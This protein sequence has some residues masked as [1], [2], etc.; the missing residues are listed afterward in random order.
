MTRRRCVPTLRGWSRFGE[1]GGAAHFDSVAAPDHLECCAEVVTRAS[2][3]KRSRHQRAEMGCAMR[4]A[5]P[6][7]EVDASPSAIFDENGN[8]RGPI[9]KFNVPVAAGLCGRQ[10]MLPVDG[11]GGAKGAPYA[12]C[13]EL[14]AA[15]RFIAAILKVPEPPLPT[16]ETTR[17]TLSALRLSSIPLLVSGSSEADLRRRQSDA[18]RRSCWQRCRES[19]CR[20]LR[21]FTRAR[22]WDRTDVCDGLFPRSS[23]I[24]QCRCAKK[25]GFGPARR[26]WLMET[27]A[28][29][30]QACGDAG[31]G[32]RGSG[33]CWCGWGS[34]PV[35]ST[36]GAAGEITSHRWL[37]KFP[38][39]AP[40][41][42]VCSHAQNR[43][44]STAIG[45]SD[46][47]ERSGDVCVL[48]WGCGRRSAT[49]QPRA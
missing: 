45:T 49:G 10:P 24:S 4:P 29:S 26:G 7:R 32:R 39:I 16:C 37:G 13:A 19:R 18:Q 46:A 20:D 27:L 30:A 48:R 23:G 8:A 21:I 1:L 3:E 36:S 11:I 6:Q 38:T 35:C 31:A 47:G 41:L 14:G 40:E 9:E 28:G 44:T 33:R 15:Q 2:A 25:R 34:A 42:Y 17:T 5:D 12:S 22:Q 43:P